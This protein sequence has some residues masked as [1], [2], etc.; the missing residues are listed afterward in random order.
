MIIFVD[1][2]WNQ[3]YLSSRVG[4][5]YLTSAKTV[6]NM[7]L[8]VGLCGVPYLYSEVDSSG[9]RIIGELYQVTESCLRGL[10]EYEGLSKGYYNRQLISVEAVRNKATVFID[11][12][13][14]TLN[15]PSS[16]LKEKEPTHEYS[17]NM[18]RSLYSP[19]AH[20]QVKQ[21]AYFGLP[22]TWGKILNQSN[23]NNGSIDD[24]IKVENASN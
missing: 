13:V 7:K 11:A 20:I 3:K 21:I 9:F 15:N 23:Q 8:V 12:F 18:H 16:Q 4:G 24:R 17:L 1:F 19:I 5:T 10:D 6:S 22:S 2:H 14:Y